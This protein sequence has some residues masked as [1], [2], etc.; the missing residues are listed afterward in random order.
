[1]IYFAQPVEGGAVKI[2]CAYCVKSRIRG[3]EDHYKRKLSLLATM[4]GDES[5]EKE[6]HARFAH[7][8]LGI[9]EQFQPAPE[10]MEFIGCPLL[11]RA[12]YAT[13]EPMLVARDRRPNTPFRLS[14]E[15]LAKL[16]AIRV[17]YG[18]PTRV[19]AVRR[20]LRYGEAMVLR[21][22]RKWRDAGM[23]PPPRPPAHKYTGDPSNP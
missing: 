19:A 20:C 3:L 13:V 6:I 8:R 7:L 10:L 4:E 22:Q 15:H 16:E 14:A 9:T 5:R 17:Y 23:E 1:M 11:G 18:L 2:G 21:E 12:D